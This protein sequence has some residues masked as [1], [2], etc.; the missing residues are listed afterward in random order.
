MNEPYN[1]PLSYGVDE[2]TEEGIQKAIN[3]YLSCLNCTEEDFG[4]DLDKEDPLFKARVQAY[5]ESS[6]QPCLNI[7]VQEGN[8][9]NAAPLDETEQT[10]LAVEAIVS[11]EI[12]SVA[13]IKRSEGLNTQEII[14]YFVWKGLSVED[15]EMF[16]KDGEPPVDKSLKLSRGCLVFVFNFIVVVYFI[17]RMV[18]NK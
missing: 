14:D 10:R 2:F 1:I 16:A 9:P 18:I 6:I 8:A 4:L 17:F 5:K 15:A 11:A 13:M 7:N 12:T 3:R